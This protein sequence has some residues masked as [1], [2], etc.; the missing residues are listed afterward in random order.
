MNL[1]GHTLVNEGKIEFATSTLYM[2]EGAKLENKGRFEVESDSE[3]APNGAA[4]E[5]PTGAKGAAPLI[6][7]TGTV[8]KYAGGGITKIDVP[9][10]N[11]GIVELTSPDGEIHILEPITAESSTQWGGAENVSTPGHPHSE[12]GDP[13]SCATGNF[14]ETQTDFAIGGRGVGLD[15]ARTYNSQ[16]A[17]EGIKGAFGYGWTISF[18]DH[19]VVNKTSKVT[20]LYQADGSAVPFTEETGGA[21]KAPVWTQDILSGTEA[22]GYTLTFANQVKDKFAGSSG[23]LES[24]TDRDGNATTL[25]YNEAGRLTTITD[26]VS[27]TI[28]LKYNGEGF[29]ESAEDPMKHVVKYTYE[30]GN[31]KSVTQPAEESL[32]WQF[33]YD[34]SHRMTE[35]VDGRSGKTINEY[36]GSN[37]VTKQEDPAGHKLKF[38]YETFQTKI[39]NENTGS[40]T[41]EYFTSDDEPASITRGY[42][43]E[44]ATTESFTSTKAATLRA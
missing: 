41:D 2:S 4:I 43:T 28:K 7:N 5:R 24:V 34:G 16:A 12:C 8:R 42:G 20:T 21:F 25:T 33:K 9:F 22:G 44:S 13:V 29:V 35:M 27:R 15:L 14:S 32:R 23:R 31:L 26:P 38:E 6:V 19:L 40:V 10:E 11:Q 37:Q 18:S 17:A 3:K 39:T 1:E 36:N 30:E